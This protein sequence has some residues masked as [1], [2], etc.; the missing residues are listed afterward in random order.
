MVSLPTQTLVDSLSLI[1]TD[2]KQLSK[3]FRSPCSHAAAIADSAVMAREI[4]VQ[5]LRKHNQPG[6]LWVAVSGIVYN[7]SAFA[8]VHP[9][10]AKVL[11][12]SPV[13]LT[14]PIP[15]TH[16]R[17]QWQILAILVRC[18]HKLCGFKI[19]LS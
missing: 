5:E 13:S 16:H 7:V 18:I 17:V 3:D 1:N 8:N 12:S 2:F 9:G 11:D 19:V 10:G 6:D 4:S 14:R 15:G